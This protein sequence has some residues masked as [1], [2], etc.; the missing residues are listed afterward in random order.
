MHSVYFVEVWLTLSLDRCGQGQLVTEVN[1]ILLLP[2][3]RLFMTTE[4][5]PILGN[6]LFLRVN[7]VVENTGQQKCNLP[8]FQGQLFYLK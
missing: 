3:V 6:A 8:V 1:T 2:S 4:L 5:L 7:H